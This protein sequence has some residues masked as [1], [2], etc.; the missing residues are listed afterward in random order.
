[1]RIIHLIDYFQPKLGYQETYLAL[2]HLR[3]GHHVTVITS[4]RH[5]PFSDYASAFQKILGERKKKPGKFKEYGLDT[6]R[7]AAIEMPFTPVIFLRNLKTAL[8]HLNPDMVFCHGIFSVVSFQAALYKEQFSY[9]LFYDSH[10]ADFNTDFENSLLKKFYY[11]LYI[12]LMAPVIKKAADRLF[13]VGEAEKK[14]LL[15][16]L[17]IP[18][19]RVEI[20][21]VG[22]DPVFLK[23]KKE[24]RMEIRRKLGISPDEFAIIYAG[25]IAPGKDL[26]VLLR[27][28]KLLEGLPVKILIIGGGN[29]HYIE[30][31]KKQYPFREKVIW[32]G[33][34]TNKMLTKYYS[35]AD[36][37]IWPG[38]PSVAVLEA[39]AAGL[40]VIISRWFGTRYLNKNKTVLSFPRGNHIKLANLIKI[41]LINSQFRQKLG[42]KAQLFIKNE[43]SW[44]K[45]A[46]QAII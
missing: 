13:A 18:N 25:K 45:I 36:T 4:D 30:K 40:P 8:A 15:R 26:P 46:K 6:L 29:V 20:L 16:F 5:Y 2:A 11:L 42:I 39:M 7:L 3:L 35:A 21:R 28:V 22:I 43:L 31:L 9:K 17:K 24:K 32:T 27:A 38:N 19:Y 23:A 10:A 12:K 14:F 34:I 1:M 41:L 44:D 37:A 33:F